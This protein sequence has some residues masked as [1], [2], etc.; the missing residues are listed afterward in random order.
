MT[1]RGST[2]TRPPEISLPLLTTRSMSLANLVLHR[3]DAHDEGYREE[4]QK[5]GT[6]D[7]DTMVE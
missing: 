5:A 7:S 6:I 1:A 3:L 2:N 4:V